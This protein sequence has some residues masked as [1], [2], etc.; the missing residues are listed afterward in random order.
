MKIEVIAA[1]SELTNTLKSEN[2]L[3]MLLL[4]DFHN[5]RRTVEARSNGTFSVAGHY[6][7]LCFK[8]MDRPKCGPGESEMHAGRLDLL[9][10]D[11][12]C[13][14]DNPDREFWLHPLNVDINLAISYVHRVV[15]RL[16]KNEPYLH[17]PVHLK[18]RRLDNPYASQ[19]R[20][21]CRDGFD[22]GPVTLKTLRPYEVAPVDMKGLQGVVNALNRV[23]PVMKEYLKTH[24]CCPVGGDWG[25]YYYLRK[26]IFSV[27]G[28]N[29]EIASRIVPIPGLF[30]IGLNCQEC[31]VLKYESFLS[32][33][34]KLIY[35]NAKAEFSVA[36]TKMSPSRRKGF[37]GKILNAWKKIRLEILSAIEAAGN[38]MISVHW[39]CLI[40]LLEEFLPL[41]M[42]IYDC[43]L[44]G[45]DYWESY[46]SLLVRAMRMFART[47][48]KHYVCL[49]MMWICDLV[50]LKDYRP[51]FYK[52]V[53]TNLHR[54]SEE[55]IELFHSTIRPYAP[56][57]GRNEGR[58]VDDTGLLLKFSFI[59]LKRQSTI[60]TSAQTTNAADEQCD[61][62]VHSPMSRSS[63][64]EPLDPVQT[65]IEENPEDF[66]TTAALETEDRY[67][68]ALRSLFK[69][70]KISKQENE[71]T[72]ARFDEKQS[73]KWISK[74]VTF[75]IQDCTLPL[76]LQGSVSAP[77]STGAKLENCK[78][79]TVLLAD[80]RE[81]R[82]TWNSS[83]A[84]PECVLRCLREPFGEE[85][86]I[87]VTEIMRSLANSAYCDGFRSN[88]M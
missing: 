25:L 58:D 15:E 28:W 49:L 86:M 40:D 26:Y 83:Y 47:G 64:F 13:G 2:I 8:V 41:S 29:D 78:K 27:D 87:C 19:Q 45:P 7:S 65:G 18:Y 30:H 76:Q 10:G 21:Q 42:D 73:G 5:I 57:T 62:D 81:N 63:E 77:G 53:R 39:A 55:E 85:E 72:A 31:I 16:E 32:A 51:E 67:A 3:A 23:K 48:K 59:G 24:E 14:A 80:R 82:I 56:V 6:T 54:L 35:P 20:L 61:H 70:S 60:A 46:H 66:E 9:F 11:L 69:E 71:E 74:A 4:D 43:S 68:D 12:P 22:H 37:L 79:H 88:S 52:F 34:W 75:S 84:A 36:T 44:N 33:L 50:Y 17:S 38:S 1:Q